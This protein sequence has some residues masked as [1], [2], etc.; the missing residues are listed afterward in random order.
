MVSLPQNR[1]VLAK[2]VLVAVSMIVALLALELYLRY[3]RDEPDGWGYSRQHRVWMERYWGANN[4]M[5]L[6][7]IEQTLPE[8]EG[9]R[10][11]VVLGDSFTEGFGIES[12]ADRYVDIIRERVG[13]NDGGDWRVVMLAKGGWDTRDQLAM[14]RRFRLTPEIVVLQY[15]INDVAPAEHFYDYRLPTGWMET[16]TTHS[17]LADFVYWRIHKLLLV[18]KFPDL[19]RQWYADPEIWNAHRADLLALV[20][21]CR[22]LHANLVALVIPRLVDVEETAVYTAKVSALLQE[23]GVEVIDVA[24][25]VAGQP[26]KSLIVG[27]DD[28]HANERLHARF[29]DLI[30]ERIS[31]WIEAS[32]LERRERAWNAEPDPRAPL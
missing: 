15:Y 7:D 23:N 5:G 4:S 26:A 19:T 2:L 8:V 24:R 12:R 20:E 22:V 11:I 21:H 1:P 30:L 32:P 14:L 6:R 17:A 10:L 28:T 9:K 13:G 16:L 18:R 29:A 3:V 27:P 25:V 31:P